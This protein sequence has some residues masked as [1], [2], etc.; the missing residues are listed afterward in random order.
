MKYHDDTPL[1][2]PGHFAFEAMRDRTEELVDRMPNVESTDIVHVEERGPDA[3]YIVR[4]FQGSA[5]Q[6]PAFLRPFVSR[7]S[8][9]WTDYS[10]WDARTLTCSWRIE[11]AHSGYSICQGVNYYLPDPKNPGGCIVRISGEFT[12]DGDNIP[13][14]PK[15]LGR[16]IAPRAERTVVGHT[17]ENFRGMVEGTGALLEAKAKAA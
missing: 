8:L 6:V 3:V 13:H 9:A 10:L 4:N 2:F 11:N 15:F 12:V 7:K 1:P 14:V 17:V 16:R 5:S